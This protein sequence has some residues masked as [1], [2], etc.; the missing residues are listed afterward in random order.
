MEALLTPFGCRID[1]I[2]DP[3]PCAIFKYMQGIE[4]FEFDAF[5]TVAH[6]VQRIPNPNDG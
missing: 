1:E 5:T 4:W 2:I 3:V 6:I